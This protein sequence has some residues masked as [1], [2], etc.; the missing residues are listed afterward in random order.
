MQDDKVAPK[1]NL[2]R[3]EAYVSKSSKESVTMIYFSNWIR[4]ESQIRKELMSL[5]MFGR[6]EI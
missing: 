6:A 3:C 1:V 4:K 5:E 2:V